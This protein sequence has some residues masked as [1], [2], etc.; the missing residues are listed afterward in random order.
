MRKQTKSLRVGVIIA[1]V[2][3]LLLLPSVILAQDGDEAAEE[4]TGSYCDDPMAQYLVEE[5]G[6][7]CEEMAAQGIGLG[8]IKKA[9]H[10]SFVLP[11][12]DSWY[13]NWKVGFLQL[14]LSLK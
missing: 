2:V 10:L 12:F 4:E 14:L 9:W 6:Y 1:L 7:N 13:C 8:E 5:Q 3:L 11:G